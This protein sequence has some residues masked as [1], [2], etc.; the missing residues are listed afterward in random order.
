[1]SKLPDPVLFLTTDV[2]GNSEEA[3][4]SKTHLRQRR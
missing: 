2:E 4:Q 3:A 1:L